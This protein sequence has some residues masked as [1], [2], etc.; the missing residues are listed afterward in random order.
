MGAKDA[1][2]SWGSQ[3]DPT[4]ANSAVSHTSTSSGPLVPA[5]ASSGRTTGYALLN[6]EN[7]E[8]SYVKLQ[9]PKQDVQKTV[10][11]LEKCLKQAESAARVTPEL[12]KQVQEHLKTLSVAFNQEHQQVET[13]YNAGRDIIITDTGV[14]AKIDDLQKSLAN[15]EY[16]RRGTNDGAR[17]DQIEQTMQYVLKSLKGEIVPKLKMQV[18][19]ELQART[20][21]ALGAIESKPQPS[22]S[23][24]TELFAPVRFAWNLFK[25]VIHWEPYE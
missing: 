18:L 2:N 23:F 25:F 20:D 24:L 19:D 21:T 17:I 15:M 9:Q 22:V 1:P 13:Q 5:E 12:R 10:N 4:K 16:I 7:N 11:N 3:T 8:P 6:S 14:K